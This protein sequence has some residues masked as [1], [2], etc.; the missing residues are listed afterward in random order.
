VERICH[1][2][3]TLEMGYGISPTHP[4]IDS[5]ILPM[6]FPSPFPLSTIK[7]TSHLSN[8]PHPIP[9]PIS[10]T[11]SPGLEKK[12]STKNGPPFPTHLPCHRRNPASTKSSTHPKIRRK[13]VAAQAKAQ[14][15]V[16]R[17][18]SIPQLCHTPHLAC[19]FPLL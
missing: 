16:F 13:R 2:T 7:I 5:I 19:L 10:C 1:K 3:I 4:F 12:Q 11:H 15:Q 9:K 8:P 6:L 14:A 18:G 17:P